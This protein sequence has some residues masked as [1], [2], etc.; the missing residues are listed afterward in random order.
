VVTHGTSLASA[1]SATGLVVSGALAAVIRSTLSR[2]ISSDATSE[3][4]L[5]L[6]WLSLVMIWTG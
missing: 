2:R 6:D 5:A 4:R 1:W 3:A